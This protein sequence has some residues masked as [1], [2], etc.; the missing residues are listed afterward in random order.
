MI[1]SRRLLANGVALAGVGR[2]AQGKGFLDDLVGDVERLTDRLET[3]GEAPAL[4][5]FE[6]SAGTVGFFQDKTH[7]GV[8]RDDAPGSLNCPVFCGGRRDTPDELCR[9]HARPKFRDKIIDQIEE[10]ADETNGRIC[11]HITR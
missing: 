1:I 10:G 2:S 7:F 8:K 5:A 4:E 9:D 6:P 3:A 11:I